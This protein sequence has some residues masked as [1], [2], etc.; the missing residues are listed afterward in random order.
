MRVRLLVYGFALGLGVLAMMLVMPVPALFGEGAGWHPPGGDQAQSLVGHLAFQADGWRWPLLS[1][2]RLFWP[3]PISIM[4][5][6]SNPLFSLMAKVWTRLSGGMPVNL[7]GMF[8]GL[9][10]LLQPVAGAYAARGLGAGQ[11]AAVAAGVL[12][13]CWPALLVRMGHINLCAHW[14]LLMALGLAFRRLGDGVVRRR[15]LTPLGLLLV[16][17][18]THPYLFQLCGAV[19]A[20]VPLQA[21]L[22]RRPG[23]WRD[24]VGFGLA[25][26]LPVGLLLVLSGPLGGGDRGFTFFSMNV[27][28]PIWP[29][30]SGVFGA[31]W[32]VIDAT[33]GQYEGFNWIG[34]GTL[35]LLVASVA[36]MVL[37]RR[38]RPA[39][40]LVLV[41]GGLTLIALSSQVWVGSVKVIDLGTRPWEDVFGSFRSSGRAF[42]PV[43]YAVMLGCVAV[44]DR[45]PRRVAWP[46]LGAAVLLQVADVRPLWAE[47]RASWVWGSGIAAPA[48]PSGT[49]L[50][51]VAPHPGCAPEAA[52]KARAPIMLLDAVR[53]GARVGDIGL[54]RSPG[55]FSCERVLSD[56]LELPLA[57]GES[58]AFFPGPA[59]ALLR[60][61]RL[62][63]EVV[64]RRAGD[65]VLCGR[66]V[67][68]FSGDDVPALPGPMALML[69]ARLN[70][71]ALPS[72]LGSGWAMGADG[73]VWSEGPRSTLLIPVPPGSDLVLRLEAAGVGM[74]DGEARSFAV[75]VGRAVL[76]GF[77]LPD[78]L[79]ETVDIPVPADAIRD[80]MVRVAFDTVR[81]ID[82]ARRSIAA[83]V[84]RAAMRLLGVSVIASPG[85]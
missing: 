10:W 57:P 23:W 5:T 20:A 42:W 18:G 77:R 2:E 29:Q 59:Q 61:D 48:V 16:A 78:G 11:V 73:A 26:A 70:A 72:V 64:C 67:A 76:A 32:P 25:A 41:L 6:D 79:T 65:V 34:A 14:L 44:V 38:V 51:T 33:G 75:T 56:A 40:G 39:A 84:K 15:W 68:G 28:G 47:A 53:Q 43:G 31:A 19:L 81:P 54:G 74:R 3:Q 13:V 1:T 66:G 60:P 8:L 49:T 50:F 63:P 85:S 71:A 58:R 62:G 55:W 37:G 27:L 30:R 4:L 35:L 46:L 52:T 82:P 80:G 83:P 7:L 24:G 9:C 45:W 21:V 69:P 12:A 22:R 17:V 36:A